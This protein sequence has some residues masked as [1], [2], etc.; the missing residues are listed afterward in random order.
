MRTY[1]YIADVVV[2]LL[3]ILIKNEKPVYN[4]G[5]RSILSI[6]DLAHKIATEL[7]VKVSIPVTDSSL[8]GAPQFVGLNLSRVEEEYGIKK[9]I[10]IEE[11]LRNTIR[12]IINYK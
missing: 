2:M 11:G 9:Y 1:G 6:K 12:W 10:G 8:D 7:N 3:N 4:V 5:G